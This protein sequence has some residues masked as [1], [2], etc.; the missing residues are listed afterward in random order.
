M[1][2]LENAFWNMSKRHERAAKSN[3][4]ERELHLVNYEEQ[5]ERFLA[6]QKK[7]KKQKRNNSLRSRR[8]CGEEAEEDVELSLEVEIDESLKDLLS[9]T[10]D[11]SDLLD[12]TIIQQADSKHETTVSLEANDISEIIEMINQH[13]ANWRRTVNGGSNGRPKEHRFDCATGEEIRSVDVG[14]G[15]NYMRPSPES[16]SDEPS[17]VQDKTT[18]YTT[19]Y[20]FND[21]KKNL[22]CLNPD[23]HEEDKPGTPCLCQHC[24]MVGVLV[25]SQK[26]PAIPHAPNPKFTPEPKSIQKK[27]LIDL[28]TKS[29]S[30][31]NMILLK[32]LTN[33]I[34]S[35]EHRLNQHEECTVR[36][37]YFKYVIHKLLTQYTSKLNEMKL[38]NNTKTV[39]IA[40]QYS[41]TTN[42]SRD[43]S[44]TRHIHANPVKIV[45]SDE[46]VFS[47][48]SHRS[49]TRKSSKAN[50]QEFRNKL[51][52]LMEDRMRTPKRSRREPKT[53]KHNDVL[54]LPPNMDDIQVEHCKTVFMAKE[55]KSPFRQQQ[56]QNKAQPYPEGG[57]ELE[58]LNKLRKEV[59]EN[60]SSQTIKQLCDLV[61]SK[62]QEKRPPPC[63][64]AVFRRNIETQKRNADECTKV[65]R[66]KRT[67]VQK[68]PRC[69]DIPDKLLQKRDDHRNPSIPKDSVRR[70]D[71]LDVAYVNPAVKSWHEEQSS[72][73]VFLNDRKPSKKA[74]KHTIQ[75]KIKYL[76]S[77]AKRKNVDETELWNNILNQAKKHI[78]SNEDTVSIQLPGSANNREMS[79]LELTLSNLKEIVKKSRNLKKKCSCLSIELN[80]KTSSDNYIKKRTERKMKSTRV[81]SS[82]AK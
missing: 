50:M 15:S 57:N 11:Y 17:V 44:A 56:Q 37:D 35:L 72:D 26:R 2:V 18:V 77:L 69:G 6:G 54:K 40:T 81:S 19:P 33:K 36:K 75:E 13:E 58:F 45:N 66:N 73:D 51:S 70:K 42:R 27:R 61:Y 12:V 67:A 47:E 38:N 80:Y 43:K 32:E 76:K 41:K 60:I 16:D 62:Y 24:G 4:S 10:N 9:S 68:D 23:I 82:G 20:T 64:D 5:P 34:I 63:N 74:N 79:E 7:E 39:T 48:L 31:T 55:S 3:L 65:H 28:R 21:V 22:S 29:K 30:E 59:D 14:G 1:T 46:T 53:E 25:E 71:K 52:T 8:C 49:A 78:K